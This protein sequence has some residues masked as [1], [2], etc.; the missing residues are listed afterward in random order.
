MRRLTLIVGS[1]FLA[2]T[3]A[4]AVTVTVPGDYAT[5]NAAIDNSATGDTIL[6]DPGTYDEIV[7][8]DGKDLVVTG[9]VIDPSTTV[10]D[11]ISSTYALRFIN[12]ETSA[13]VFEGFTVNGASYNIYTSALSNATVRDCII[14]DATI[15]PVYLVT[16][17]GINL[18]NNTYT[19]NATEAI[20]VGGATYTRSV[21][22]TNDGLPYHVYGTPSVW[23]YAGNPIPRLTIDPG[24]D[25]LF[26]NGTGFAVGSSWDRGGEVYAVGTIAEP[27]TFGPL[28]GIAGGWAGIYFN[29]GSDYSTSASQMEYCEIDKAGGAGWSYTAAVQLNA[30]L[31]PTFTNSSITDCVGHAMRLTAGAHF[32]F[33]ED[34]AMTNNNTNTIAITATTFSED[35]TYDANGIPF[36]VQ[37]DINVWD[38]EGNPIPRLTIAPGNTFQFIL[39]AGLKI[40]SSWNRGGE[41]YAV[42]T[43]ANPITFTSSSGLSGDWDGINFADGSDYNATST[44]EFCIVEKAG[45]PGWGYSANL[46][47]DDTDQPTITNSML[48][49]CDG[50]AVWLQDQAFCSMSGNIITGNTSD[51]IGVSARTVANSFTWT[52]NDVPYHVLGHFY[53]WD[54]DTAPEAPTLTIE[55]GTEI[56]FAE[57]IG[58]QIGSSS[59]TR[60]GQLEAIGTELEPIIFGAISGAPGGWAG[61]HF[62]NSTDH[63]GS[64]STLEYC[65]FN[66]GGYHLWAGIG[67]TVSSSTTIQPSITNCSFTESSEYPLYI[68]SDAILELNNNTYTDNAIQAI[69]FEGRTLST[70]LLMERDNAPYHVLATIYMQKNTIPYPTLTIEPG[71]TLQFAQTAGMRFGTTGSYGGMLNAVGTELLPITFT[72]FSGLEGGWGG[73]YFPTGSDWDGVTSTMDWCNVNRAGY[74]HHGFSANMKCQHTDQ[75][76]VTNCNFLYSSFDGLI[77]DDYSGSIS[78]S[79]M[80]LNDGDGIH[81]LGSDTQLQR[82]EMSGNG[83][84]GISLS[85][86]SATLI[87]SGVGSTCQ[88]FANTGYNVRVVAGADTVSARFNYWGTLDSLEIEASIYDEQDDGLLGR[89]DWEPAVDVGEGQNVFIT[90][91]PYHTPVVIGPGGGYFRFTAQIE[92][93]ETFTTQ[94]D[95]W[96]EWIL[97]NLTV[98]SPVDLYQNINLP[99]GYTLSVT[100]FQE[101]PGY[102]PTGT[103]QFVA[104]I[105]DYPTATDSMSFEVHKI[106]FPMPNGRFDSWESYGWFGSD[107]ADII[108]ELEAAAAAAL[109]PTEFEIG[110][111]YPN[112]FNAM[113]N[114]RVS[115]PEAADVTVAVYNVTG[116]LVSTVSQGNMAAGYHTLTVDGTRLASGLYFVRADIAGQMHLTRKMMLVK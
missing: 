48:R 37:G 23:A 103:F 64:T 45:L 112:P 35:M 39:N 26:Q 31:Q 19:N 110:E 91:S 93:Q 78:D 100:P 1:L 33:V 85:N 71:T 11:G 96:T 61:L 15:Y 38:Y 12:G 84:D 73:L 36:E 47:C 42:G 20:Y 53:I 13:A 104:K 101:L 9:D 5:I 111:I 8:F 34:I 7:T 90:I 109:L 50:Y 24:T 29:D 116:Q 3:L 74:N 107:D 55:P 92:N 99:A 25:L 66:H 82:V 17:A 76:T 65:Q 105:G 60:W 22:F 43:F 67:S 28:T 14:S 54:Y 63:N 80:S 62:A 83:D 86:S 10:I 46:V 2:A 75:P 115:L 41:L 18:S 69:G 98:M 44:M 59:A 68:H 102:A 114:L 77:L 40:G 106:E 81:A 89:V 27:I 6:V 52:K 94:I 16:G 56:L 108:A 87:G 95:A 32:A 57:T 30:T 88:M 97:P 49:D 79:R 4:G 72:S 70:D 51:A 21:N 58:M 113:A